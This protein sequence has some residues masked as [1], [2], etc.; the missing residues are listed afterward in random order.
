MKIELK[1]ITDRL[2][3]GVWLMSCTV[4][5][6]AFS[7]QLRKYLIKPKPIEWIDSWKGLY[8]WKHLKIKTFSQTSLVHYIECLKVL[9]NPMGRDFKN[10]LEIFEDKEFVDG[11]KKYED[12]LD[13]EGIAKGRVALV[14]D[15]NYLK[16]F[17]HILLEMG[18]E[19]NT[20]F[21]LSRIEEE[22]QPVFNFLNKVN[23]YEDLARKY[24]LAYVFSICNNKI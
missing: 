2:L 20:D 3:S 8:E 10:R 22:S 19:E 15:T 9:E 17:K 5:L 16:I 12:F 24:N 23:L 18:F 6:A 13:F 11:T 4:L 1:S 7:G 21:R 14:W